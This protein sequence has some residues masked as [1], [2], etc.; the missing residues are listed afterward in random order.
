MTSSSRITTSSKSCAASPARPAIC[1]AKSSTA[2]MCSKARGR[3]NIPTRRWPRAWPAP[4]WT[5]AS[6][7]LGYHPFPAPS[8]NA[9]EVYTNPE[10]QTLGACEYCGHCERFGCEANAKASPNVCILPVLLADPKFELRTH[11][12]VKEL[13]YDKAARKVTAVRYVDTAQRRG[14]RAARRHRHPRRLRV[15]QRAADARPPASASP[16]TTRPAKAP[17]AR[18]TAIRSAAMR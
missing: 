13:V 1:A 11:A 16:T 14:I 17:S 9:S 15:Q 7:S 5:E 8:S 12:L 3:T 4:S 10:G 6:K 2:A 18:T